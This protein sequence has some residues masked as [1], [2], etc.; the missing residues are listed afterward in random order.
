MS[1]LAAGHY[2]GDVNYELSAGVPCVCGDVGLGIISLRFCFSAA[3]LE[4]VCSLSAGCQYCRKL[5]EAGTWLVS[6][7]QVDNTKLAEIFM[8][9]LF[10]KLLSRAC[11]PLQ[12]RSVEIAHAW[13]KSRSQDVSQPPGQHC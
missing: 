4:V 12:R 1:P 7:C 3:H 5:A 8:Q 6:T 10:E 2:V 13:S 9:L 11:H